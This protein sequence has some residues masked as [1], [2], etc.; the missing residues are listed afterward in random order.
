MP[1]LLRALVPRSVTGPRSLQFVSLC[2]AGITTEQ[3]CDEAFSSGLEHLRCVMKKRTAVYSAE[4]KA[5]MVML[6]GEQEEERRREQ[7]KRLKKERERHLQRKRRVRA[8]LFGGNPSVRSATLQLCN[9]SHHT[10]VVM[11]TFVSQRTCL[12]IPFCSPSQNITPRLSARC[13]LYSKSG[14]LITPHSHNGNH[15]TCCHAVKHSYTHA[16]GT[17]NIK[18]HLELQGVYKMKPSFA[19]A[20]EPWSEIMFLASRLHTL[21]VTIS[22]ACWTDRELQHDKTPCD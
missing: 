12:L 20:K 3:Q 16:G 19:R 22:H 10:G 1:F 9:A 8:M 11:P 6:E 13:T 5:L 15:E 21:T 7:E 14:L 17:H 18:K 2:A 4:E